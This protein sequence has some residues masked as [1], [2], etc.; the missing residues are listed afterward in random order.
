MTASPVRWKK[1]GSIAGSYDAIRLDACNDIGVRLGAFKRT[2]DGL[3]DPTHFAD[4]KSV[5]EYLCKTC[6]MPQCIAAR[7]L[8]LTAKEITS[9]LYSER[10]D[11][12]RVTGGFSHMER[13]AHLVM[14]AIGP[15]PHWD[16]RI[17]NTKKLLAVRTRELLYF[18]LRCHGF[19]YPEIG[20][21][22][23]RNHSMVITSVGRLVD[24]RLSGVG[25]L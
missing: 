11:L 3:L 24:D 25:E 1:R 22:F 10:I 20:G 17:F 6:E 14:H 12:S 8:G 19:S 7:V 18:G 2:E 13:A 5:I 16:H 9:H 15:G 23:G 4:R 21:M